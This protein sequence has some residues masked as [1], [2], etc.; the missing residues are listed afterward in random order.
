MAK[1]EIKLDISQT[2]LNKFDALFKKFNIKWDEKVF[3][4]TDKL[5]DRIKRLNES[6]ML[7]NRKIEESRLRTANQAIK[8]FDAG[9]KGKAGAATG[10]VPPFDTSKLE[11]SFE[12]LVKAIED[13]TAKMGDM[14]KGTEDIT[15]LTFDQRRVIIDDIKQRELSILT[16][17]ET[18][19]ERMHVRRTELE[20][21]HAKHQQ[22][23]KALGSWEESL[24]SAG[25]L[26]KT[27]FTQGDEMMK[28]FTDL[29]KY[30]EY[31]KTGAGQAEMMNYEKAGM[32]GNP[33]AQMEAADKM[34]K[35]GGFGGSVG[36]LQE[37]SSSFM[38]KAMGKIGSM[39]GA[40]K[41][42]GVGGIASK[43]GGAKGMMAIGGAMVGVKMIQ[44]GVQLAI[45]SSPMMQQMLKLWKFGIMMIFRPLGDFFGFFLRPIFVYLLRKFIIP[46][47][48]TY[49]PLMQELGH[50]LGVTVV[51]LLEV[52]FGVLNVLRG[53]ASPVSDLLKGVSSSVDSLDPILKSDTTL[54]TDAIE[55]SKIKSGD[56]MG[57]W[58]RFAEQLFPNQ[59]V[60]GYNV[61][62]IG[63]NL[64]LTQAAADFYRELGHQVIPTLKEGSGRFDSSVSTFS[65]ATQQFADKVGEI[66]VGA[67]GNKGVGREDPRKKDKHTIIIIDNQGNSTQ[68]GDDTTP[69]QKDQIEDGLEESRYQSGRWS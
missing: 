13:A 47:Y 37:K 10:Q 5:S 65:K 3:K 46:F 4:S 45:A 30:Q 63:D 23:K 53:H 35:G 16:D 6:V 39:F 15:G 11:G 51:G 41:E 54:I 29:G 17:R 28:P 62:G 32:G 14:Q 61:S 26:L 19:K 18:K 66:S 60:K 34:R 68:T 49:L 21:L 52:I 55:K 25:N 27:F 36:S 42:G 50:S 7:W 56:L 43:L 24:G 67:A 8:D 69:E 59:D 2:S 57:D 58:Q 12:R 31:M 64:P 9:T 22:E 38:G 48:Q 40:G 20:N 44:K 33:M 1:R